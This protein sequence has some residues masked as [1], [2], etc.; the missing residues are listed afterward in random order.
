MAGDQNNEVGTSVIHYCTQGEAIAR[1]NTLIVGNGHPEDGLAFKTAKMTDDV[2]EIKEVVKKLEV[3]YQASLDAAISASHGLDQYKAEM[4]QFE[5]GKEAI[6]VRG[7]LK[8]TRTTQII[9]AIAAVVLLI[10]GYINLERSIQKS[11]TAIR[12]EYKHTE[13][14]DSTLIKTK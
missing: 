10:F 7:N 3:M 11:F 9:S 8:V 1:L 4:A 5:A 14:V 2:A 12:A 13:M 6:R